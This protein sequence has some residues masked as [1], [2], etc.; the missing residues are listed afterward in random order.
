MAPARVI[1]F[2]VLC[3]SGAVVFVGFALVGLV[4]HPLAGRTVAVAAV[5]VPRGATVAVG[6]AAGMGFVP[7][8]GPCGAFMALGIEFATTYA[9]NRSS[10]RDRHRPLG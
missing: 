2:V 8:P 6:T 7:V 9:V 3:R 4:L 5:T 1:G 10:R